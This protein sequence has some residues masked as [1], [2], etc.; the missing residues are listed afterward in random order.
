MY[1]REMARLA[2][3][4]INEYISAPAPQ[5]GCP[6]QCIQSMDADTMRES[7]ALPIVL[8]MSWP[9]LFLPHTTNRP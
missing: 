7:K 4:I 9:A 6:K 3:E 8:S 1:W 2:D 5:I